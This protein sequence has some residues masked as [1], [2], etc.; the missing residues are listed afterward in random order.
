MACVLFLFKNALINETGF[1]TLELINIGGKITR[2][3]WLNDNVPISEFK[4]INI[5]KIKLGA[6]YEKLS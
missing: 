2:Q 3:D 4:F 5:V 6:F 1:K